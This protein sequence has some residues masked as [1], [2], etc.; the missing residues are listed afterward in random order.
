MKLLYF[1]VET[2]GL[3]AAKCAIHQLSGIIEINGEIVETFNFK[4]APFVGAAISNEALKISNV[5]ESEIKDYTMD[6]MMLHAAFKNMILKYIDKYAKK[7]KM[8]LVG[9]N[10]ASFDNHFLRA[11]F[12]R[13]SDN[14]FGSLFWANPIDVYVIASYKTMNE[15]KDMPA[16]KLRNACE[17]FNIPVE[18]SRLHDAIYDV[19]LTRKLFKALQ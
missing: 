13:N 2:T 15:R 19:E 18:E 10:S 3:S 4:A 12:L 7:D 8:F 11:L 16:F 17:H 5:T 9:Y 6:Y 14:Y 1:D